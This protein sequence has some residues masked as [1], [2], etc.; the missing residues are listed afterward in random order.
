M[1][2]DYSTDEVSSNEDSSIEGSSI[3]Y[4]SKYMAAYVY[5]DLC[6]RFAANGLFIDV[7]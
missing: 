6:E 7:T 3:D 2:E 4:R 1:D 5:Y